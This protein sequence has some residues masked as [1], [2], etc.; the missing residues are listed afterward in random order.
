MN[1]AT[2]T[3]RRLSLPAEL[4]PSAVVV[5]IDTREQV[6]ADVQRRWSLN[7]ARSRRA[8]FRGLRDL[9]GVAAIERAVAGRPV[10]VH[11]QRTRAIRP[12]SVAAAVAIP[13]RAIV[14]ESTWQEIET[15][16]Y[17]SKVTP[18]AAIGSLLG[19]VA[20]GVP[21]IMAADRSWRRDFGAVVAGLDFQVD[22]TTIARTG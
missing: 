10:G 1:T 19:W 5:T 9:P 4:P 16:N 8:I 13:V 21:I 15:G 6:P 2:Q 14:V 11:R 18:Q 3:R 22:S 20:M 7:A 12:R 17:R